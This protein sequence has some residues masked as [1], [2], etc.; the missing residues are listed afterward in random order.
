MYDKSQ[1][2]WKYR[3]NQYSIP[4]V[5]VSIS[6]VNFILRRGETKDFTISYI[7]SAVGTAEVTYTLKWE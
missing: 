2:A 1:D 4:D 7:S 3:V 5:D 6:P